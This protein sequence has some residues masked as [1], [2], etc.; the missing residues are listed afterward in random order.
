MAFNPENASRCIIKPGYRTYKGASPDQLLP[1]TTPSG[2]TSCQI[3]SDDFYVIKLNGRNTFVHRSAIDQEITR[4]LNNKIVHANQ[5]VNFNAENNNPVTIQLRN[6]TKSIETPSGRQVIRVRNTDK[7]ES[8]VNLASVESIEVENETTLGVDSELAGR[9]ITTLSSQN[10]VPV[11]GEPNKTSTFNCPPGL[12]RTICR[13]AQSIDHNMELTL[14]GRRVSDQ[15]SDITYVEATYVHDGRQFSGWFDEK[16][17]TLDSYLADV[18]EQTARRVY[19]TMDEI[20][21]IGRGGEALTFDSAYSPE[22]SQ[23]ALLRSLTADP[24][25]FPVAAQPEVTL[26]TKSQPQ[27]S[28]PEVRDRNYTTNFGSPVCG[29]V[30]RRCRVS[31]GF[32]PRRSFRTNNGNQAS[33]NHRAW[34]IASGTGTPVVA[35]A[36]GRVISVKRESGWGKTIRVDHGNGLIVRYSHLNSYTVKKGA[37][38]RRGQQIAKMGTTGNVTGPHLDIAFIKN[39]TPVNPGNYIQ[40]NSEFLNQSCGAL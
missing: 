13:N 36:D 33:R 17:T 6:T 40:N 12:T 34:D 35:V 26:S 37:R 22:T 14:T 29:C 28:L 23:A 21:E 5:P 19:D 32:G 2:S 15:D 18:R 31:S 27:V 4:Q 1:G 25:D 8:N 7:P 16:Q 39:G 30:G 24:N 9:K 11:R 3:F 20:S 38:V 10:W